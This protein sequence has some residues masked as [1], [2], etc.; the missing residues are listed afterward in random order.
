MH[1]HFS[2]IW[3][4]LGKIGQNKQLAAVDKWT[5]FLLQRNFANAQNPPN[6][7]PAFNSTVKN[8]YNHSKLK[9]FKFLKS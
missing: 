7:T 2:C 4:T 3:A 8:L 6:I 5:F 1:K 9:L